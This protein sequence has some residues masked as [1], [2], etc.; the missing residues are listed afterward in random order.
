MTE[1]GLMVGTGQNRFSPETPLT[2]A[3]AVTLADRLHLRYYPENQDLFHPA[4]PEEP[5]YA[6]ALDYARELGFSLP[7]GEA[8]DVCTREGFVLLLASAVPRG[9]TEAKYRGDAF[10][11]DDFVNAD[12]RRAALRFYRAGI[13]GGIQGDHGAVSFQPQGELTRA[14]CAAILARLLDPESRL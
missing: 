13:V 2:V 3:Q 10:A 9:E 12:T 1:A 6:P 5:W 8:G 11:A 7:E 4:S 14:Q